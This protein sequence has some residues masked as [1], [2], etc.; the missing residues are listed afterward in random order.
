VLVFGTK[1]IFFH[2]S[3]VWNCLNVVYGFFGRFF[4]TRRIFF[5]IILCFR[6]VGLGGARVVFDEINC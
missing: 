1:I 5:L 3:I 2:V 6:R 4:I